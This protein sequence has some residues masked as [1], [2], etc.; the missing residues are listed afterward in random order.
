[1]YARVSVCILP[2]VAGRVCC[3]RLLF[4]LRLVLQECAAALE[5]GDVLA[6]LFS[7]LN[8]LSRFYPLSL[9]RRIPSDAIFRVAFSTTAMM[10]TTPL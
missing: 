7:L 6:Q 5:A 8:H 2:S 10:L 4:T 1:M 3:V 9:G